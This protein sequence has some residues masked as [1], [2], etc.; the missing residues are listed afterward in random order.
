[1][2]EDRIKPIATTDEPSLE[3]SRRRLEKVFG[4]E[5]PTL[6]KYSSTEDYVDVRNLNED[7]D[8]QLV[9]KIAKANCDR[10]N[11]PMLEDPTGSQLEHRKNGERRV[12]YR[13]DAR[14]GAIIAERRQKIRRKEDLEYF[15][16]LI[17][18]KADV[19]IGFSAYPRVI[20]GGS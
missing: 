6:E 18:R 8:M 1:M 10:V 2:I 9:L 7:G 16:S 11:G 12:R 19:P 3:S 20:R 5:R 14:P 17:F 15:E 4:G 13:R